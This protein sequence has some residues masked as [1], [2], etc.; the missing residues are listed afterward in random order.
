MMI[1]APAF[2]DLAARAKA[3]KGVA[4]PCPQNEEWNEEAKG[5]YCIQGFKRSS[6]GHCVPEDKAQ[7]YQDGSGNYDDGYNNNEYTDES[8]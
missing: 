6:Y 2:V 7:E 4:I 5:C 8:G 1:V 3:V